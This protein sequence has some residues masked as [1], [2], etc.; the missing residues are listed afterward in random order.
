M[1][2]KRLKASGYR[3]FERLEL[4]FAPGL[5]LV[6][7]PNESGK[8]T[9]VAA[10]VDCLY[11]KP[12]STGAAVRSSRRWGAAQEP[13]LELEFTSGGK[14][15][16][17]ARDFAA[18]TALLEELDG[19]PVLDNGKAISSR[20]AGLVGFDSAE[21]FTRTACVK[22]DQLAALASDAAGA[23][24]LA[25]ML[26]E[27]VVG[28][29]ES[30]L[31]DRAVAELTRAVEELK[32][33]LDRPAK[34]PGI[35]RRLEDERKAL[36]RRREAEAGLAAEHEKSRE[37]LADIETN[38][39]SEV[40]RL[41]DVRTLLDKNRE[42]SGLELRRE[43][44][45]R[46][47][48][49]AGS[50][51]AVREE[52]HRDS[53]GRHAAGRHAGPAWPGW[54][55]ASAGVLTAAVAAFLGTLNA[56][57]F[58]LLVPAILLVAAGTY[59]ISSSSGRE[60][61]EARPAAGA[62]ACEMARAELID[63]RK[64]ASMEIAGIDGRLAELEPFRLAP[65]GLAAHERELPELEARVEELASER[66][67]LAFHLS[68]VLVDVDGVLAL[69]EELAWVEE[70]EARE[71]RRLRVC[72]IALEAMGQ[73][74]EVMLSAAVPALEESLGRTLSALTAGR[75]D[76]VAVGESD[77]GLSVF[78]PERG[79]MIPAGEILATLSRGTACQLYLAARLGLV[80][81]LAGGCSPPLIFDDSFSHFDDDR[82]RRAWEMLLEI[83]RA[84]QVLLLTC[85][86]RY[87]ALAGPGV[88]IIDLGL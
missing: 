69:D 62:A 23:R 73:A 2:I 83:S 41:E 79:G 29:V 30:A 58:V 64:R 35:L 45:A 49:L 50:A 78:S 27:V 75:Y 10:I 26:R 13:A 68:R 56:A 66:E 25:S 4:D 28:D 43:R 60:S 15:Y 40:P 17:L 36:E 87:D 31:V 19:G 6:R 14:G 86:G 34:N 84:R 74:R 53:G 57:L 39:A 42:L 3:R 20:V 8:T 54:A 61:S 12:T 48:E 71:R 55:L 72:S 38:L 9:L 46:D 21:G 76:T 22:Q 47:F 24:R 1:R 82:L 52:M 7:G 67:A 37:R 81:L 33:G 44:A 51:A 88:N 65:E 11:T 77:L 63:A 85:T 32:K 70:E 18:R 5:N 80:D 16:R 59:I